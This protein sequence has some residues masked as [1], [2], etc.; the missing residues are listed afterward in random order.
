[1]QMP[2]SRARRGADAR[3]KRTEVSSI[4]LEGRAV[5]VAMCL[6]QLGSLLPHVVVPSILAAFLIPE[7]HLSGAQ[8]GLLAG[9]GAAGYMLAVPVLATPTGR[10]DR[11]QN[12]I[13]DSAVS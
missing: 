1:M 5:I 13:P 7:W 12:L 4:F 10:I 11:S 2:S 6:G 3:P 9:S 8:A